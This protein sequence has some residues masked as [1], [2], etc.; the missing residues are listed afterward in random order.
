MAQSLIDKRLLEFSDRTLHISKLD[1]DQS[2]VRIDDFPSCTAKD[3]IDLSSILVT[4]LKPTDSDSLL[5]MYFENK[6]RSGGGSI[7]AIK[8][9]DQTVGIVTFEEPEGRT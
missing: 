8:R 1:D 3:T 2:F 5:K 6:R 7:Q 9:R 4:N